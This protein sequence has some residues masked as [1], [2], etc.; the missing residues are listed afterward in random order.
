MSSLPAKPSVDQ[1]PAQ[2]S[3]SLLAPSSTPPGGFWPTVAAL[4]GE[5]LAAAVDYAGLDMCPDVFGPRLELDQLAAAVD[6]L[7]RSF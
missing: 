6:W 5:R 4:A 3:G 7:L 1:Q 2:R